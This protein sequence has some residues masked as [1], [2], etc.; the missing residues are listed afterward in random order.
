MSLMETFNASH[1][2]THF[3]KVLN[4]AEQK[5][6]RV[7]RRGHAPA[8]ILPESEYQALLEKVFDSEQSRKAKALSRMESWLEQ[9]I[10]F[11][12][13][14]DDERAQAIIAKHGKHWNQS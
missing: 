8:V 3:S 11:K 14:S 10:E 6:V 12:D 13:I 7:K 4:V 2:K 5:P 9:P 1:V